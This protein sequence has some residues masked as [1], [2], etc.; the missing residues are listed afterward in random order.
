MVSNSQLVLMIKSAALKIAPRN[1]TAIGMNITAIPAPILQKVAELWCLRAS[2]RSPRLSFRNAD[3]SCEMQRGK[4][5]IAIKY[6]PT[7]LPKAC[8]Y[9]D[10]YPGLA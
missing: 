2:S 6:I 8:V 1:T 3:Y 9:L 4:V 7:Y 5:E 10:H